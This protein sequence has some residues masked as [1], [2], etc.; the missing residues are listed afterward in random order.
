MTEETR[1]ITLRK[2]E[3]RKNFIVWTN[4]I[5]LVFVSLIVS[6]VF[7][8][9]ELMVTLVPKYF[10][11]A[12]K[13]ASVSAAVVAFM[14][15]LLASTRLLLVGENKTLYMMMCILFAVIAGALGDIGFLM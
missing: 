3:I 1:P 13:I 9:P 11:L 10:S 4:S 8:P 2:L 15:Y 7:M 14:F 5:G 6:S 12:G